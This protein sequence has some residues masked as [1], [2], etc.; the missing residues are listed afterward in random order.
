MTEPKICS[1]REKLKSWKEIPIGGAIEKPGTSLK[2]NT[3]SW[4]ILKP[5]VDE[6]KCIHCLFCAQFC[7]D[8]CI[9]MAKDGKRGSINYFYCKGCGICAEECP[10]KCIA[11][12]KEGK[13]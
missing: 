12:V 1:A 8:N 6:K 2:I 7:P 11:M 5:V 3:G 10:V 13:E 4:K 9:L